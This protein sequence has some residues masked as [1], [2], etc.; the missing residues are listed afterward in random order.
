MAD[1]KKGHIFAI[2][3]LTD[4][5]YVLAYFFT[6]AAYKN[7]RFLAQA[8]LKIA[9]LQRISHNQHNERDIY[10]RHY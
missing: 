10:R 2:L 6:Y 5:K 1:S 8:D 4:K 7:F 9:V 3:G